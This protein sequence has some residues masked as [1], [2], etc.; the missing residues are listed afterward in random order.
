MED[1]EGD[2]RSLPARK[3]GIVEE[4]TFLQRLLKGGL[5][6]SCAYM[7][8]DAYAGSPDVR[9]HAQVLQPTSPGLVRQRIPGEQVQLC[10]T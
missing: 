8:E 10:P 7:L 4:N 9:V 5:W 3:N 1:K 6:H 2:G